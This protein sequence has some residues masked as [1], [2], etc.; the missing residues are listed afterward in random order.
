MRGSR[1]LSL[2][3]GEVPNTYST[4]FTPRPLESDERGER[5]PAPLSVPGNV[6]PGLRALGTMAIP[7]VTP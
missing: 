3:V 7:C 2:L 4:I 1:P 6:A 5:T